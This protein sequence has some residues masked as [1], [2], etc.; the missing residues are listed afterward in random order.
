M[1]YQVSRKNYIW[2]AAFIGVKKAAPFFYNFHEKIE[3]LELFHQVISLKDILWDKSLL[4]T[5]NVVLLNIFVTL[6]ESMH[7]K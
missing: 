7:R 6:V 5:Q 4:I 2:V 3:I 1:P